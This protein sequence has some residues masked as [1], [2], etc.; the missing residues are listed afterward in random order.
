MDYAYVVYMFRIKRRYVH[1]S[2]GVGADAAGPHGVAHDGVT[3]V[4]LSKQAGEAEERGNIKISR[5]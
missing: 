3:T 5:S 2:G 1:L 4:R